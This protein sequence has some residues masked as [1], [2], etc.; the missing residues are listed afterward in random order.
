MLLVVRPTL[1]VA[2]GL[3]VLVAGGGAQGRAGRIAVAAGPIRG[4]TQVPSPAAAQARVPVALGFF[5]PRD[6]LLARADGTLLASVDGG[7]SWRRRGRLALEHVDVLSATLAYATTKRVLLRTDDAGKHWRVVAHVTGDLSFADPLHG[8]IM[9]RRA[10]A[11]DD[12][13]RTLRRLR[14]PCEAAGEQSVVLSRVSAKFGYA[15]CGGGM[16]AGSQLKRLYVTTDAGKRWR[17]R[18][19]ERQ[20]PAGGYVNSLSFADANNGF[21]TTARGGLLAT[22]DGGRHWRMLLFSDDATDVVAV[23][24]LRGHELVALLRNGALLRSNDGGSRWRLVYPHTLPVPEQLSYSSVEDGIGAGYADW[25]FTRQAILATRDGGRSWHLLAPLPRDVSIASLDR[26]TPSLV[27][28]VGSSYRRVGTVLF[29]SRDDGRSLQRLRTPRRARFFTVSFTSPRIG[30]LGD[31]SGRFYATHDGG[32][33]WALVH[34]GG[35]DLRRFAFLTP[36]HGFALAEVP[37]G[38]KP[39]LYE[40][41]DGGRSWH[42]YADAPVERPLAFTTHGAMLIWIID[43]PL[44]AAAVTQ[45]QPNCPG[46]IVRSTDGGRSWQRIGLNMIP[47]SNSL[48]FPTASVGYAEDPWSGSYRTRD[49]GRDWTLT[50]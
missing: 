26:V 41:L 1:A 34:G 4:H 11:T 6:A 36:M 37:A 29:R 18:A 14:N 28:M 9:A 42:A 40:T 31:D 19:G 45:H 10:L 3:I 5:G 25:A 27:Y 17:L 38:G 49:G 32:S 33:S 48:D 15:L 39:A 12:G 13:G 20:V 23:Q 30:V 21:M 24:R 22:R 35:V 16:G 7:R 2:A 50:R 44:C 8:W 47:G 46:T 43:M